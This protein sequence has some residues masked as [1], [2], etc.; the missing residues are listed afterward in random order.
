MG[1]KVRILVVDD[2]LA[3]LYATSRI[4]QHHGYEVEQA[5]NG[6][7]C[8]EK[9]DGQP[10]VILLDVRLPDI[11]GFEVARRLKR[12]PMT[13]HI[14]ILQ[15]SASYRGNEHIVEGLES[16][17]D[18]YLTQPVEPLVLVATIKSL[19]RIGNTE[20]QIRRERDRARRYFEN[21][22]IMMLVVNEDETVQLINK[23]GTKVLGYEEEEIIGVNWFDKFVPEH[24]REKIRQVFNQLKASDSEESHYHEGVVVT[25][26]GEERLIAWYTVIWDDG[27][28]KSA[29]SSGE[30]ITERRLYEDRLKYLSLNDQLTGTYNRTYFEEELKRLEGG[31][32]Y[33]VSIISIDMNGLKL[34]NDTMGHKAGDEMLRTCANL[35]RKPLRKSD[36]LAR[37]GGDEF[38]IVLS[39]TDEKAAALVLSRIGKV[40]EEHNNQ[41]HGLPVS[42]ALG[43]ATTYGS[44]KM[45]DEVLNQADAVMY[46]QKYA[47]RSQVTKQLLDAL[48][49]RLAEKDYCTEGHVQSVEELSLKLAER[50]GLSSEQMDKLGLLARVHDLGKLSIPREILEKKEPL[51]MS[52]W[53]MIKQHP[54]RGARIAKAFPELYSVVNLILGH[55]ERWDGLGYPLGLKGE[56][57][58]IECR[59]FSIADAYDVMTRVRP[60]RDAKSEAEAKEELKSNEGTQF[61]PKLVRVFLE[62]L[63]E[64]H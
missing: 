44:D 48:L 31:R 6:K 51:S 28:V 20:A 24:S 37:I 64:R 33:P 32:D 1:N 60:Y 52:E 38:V 18:T 36:F 56:E 21:A 47:T 22:G 41:L 3:G 34:I 7:E 62:I 30:D 42:M 14:P 50:I 59:V 61:D 19:L 46:E 15:F 45:L 2:N 49:R 40:I 17:A 43:T 39:N 53:Q 54:E 9:A 13:M 26:S 23:K 35:L 58:P 57:I 10:D 16:G 25:R 55:H 27:G 12:N 29:L 5:M 4:L 11:D 63:E 8:L